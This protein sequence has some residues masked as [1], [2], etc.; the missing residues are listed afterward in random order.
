[1]AAARWG[2]DPLD[3]AEEVFGR[4]EDSLWRTESG[5]EPACEH[6]PESGHEREREERE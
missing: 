3:L 4:G 6:G 1:M 2:A 5:D